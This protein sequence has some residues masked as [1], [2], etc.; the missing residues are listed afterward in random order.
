MSFFIESGIA[1]RNRHPA[2]VV[3]D[4]RI[5]DRDIAYRAMV[6]RA[7]SLQ[8]LYEPHGGRKLRVRESK[9]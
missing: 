4:D 9:P 1:I 6:A 5:E 3:V 8:V 7:H 2:W